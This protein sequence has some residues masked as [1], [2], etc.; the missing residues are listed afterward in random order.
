LV[1]EEPVADGLAVDLNAAAPDAETALGAV[2]GARGE[3]GLLGRFPDVAR[4]ARAIGQELFE[5]DGGLV[6]RAAFS[7]S[8][9]G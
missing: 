2:Q 9:D 1:G 4:G 6:A 5:K 7:A 8:H 3:V